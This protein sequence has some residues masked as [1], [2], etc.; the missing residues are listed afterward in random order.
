[1]L[2]RWARHR[3]DHRTTL[4]PPLWLL[5]LGAALTS[6]GCAS[7]PAAGVIPSEPAV[8]GAAVVV[9]VIDGDT[10]D[11]AIDGRRERVRL[12]GIDTPEVARPESGRAAECGA[13]SATAFT[14][15]LLPDG[16]DVLLT[17]DVVGRDHYGRLLAYVHRIDD[18]V[19]V[20][21]ELARQGHAD[22]LHIEPN[23]IHRVV[24]ADAVAQARS[25]RAGMWGVCRG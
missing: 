17:R 7:H 11:V 8:S 16:T 25:E 14:A 18:G 12:L 1:M 22:T 23:G 15:S 2:R 10:I 6:A 19:F 4:S 13:D 21:Y 9:E 20:N 24:L 5:G 3:N